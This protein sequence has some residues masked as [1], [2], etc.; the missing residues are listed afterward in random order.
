MAVEEWCRS[1]NT[2]I[3]TMGKSMKPKYDKYW[4]KSNMALSEACLLD[5]R[6][7]RT[8]LEYYADKVYGVVAP[9][10]MADFMVVINKL[11]DTYASSQASSKSPA[12]T[13]VQNNLLVSKDYDGESDDELDA[14][15]QQYLRASTAPGIGTKSELEVYLEQ[16]L[17]EWYTSDKTTFNILHWWSLKQHEFPI[18]SFSLDLLVMFWLFKYQL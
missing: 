5:P 12:A 9:K 10:H 17:L 11:F 4:E 8:L 14:D 16:P 6:F 2:I 7:K 15:V 3:A 18:L 13:N 1:S